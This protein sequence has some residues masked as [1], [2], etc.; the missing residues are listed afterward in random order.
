MK[1]KHIITI[2]GDHASGQ[3]TLANNINVKLG[4]EIYRNGQYARK[5]A[6]EMGMDIVEF[7]RYLNEHEELDRAIEKS[8]TEYAEEHDNLV[9]DAKLGWY[10]VP[11]SFKVYLRVDIDVAANRVFYDKNRKDSE[12]F[13]TI[14]E[15]KQKIIFRH[16]EEN[17]RWFKTYGINRDDMSNYDLVIDTT[18][19]TADEVCNKV[20]ESY[21]NWLNS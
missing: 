5:L 3:G 4:Y 13:E 15:T 8:A 7:Q 11:E 10:A 21:N 20:I 9:I 2:A 16:N 17:N 18:D 12:S 1:K 14:E 19:L 6:K